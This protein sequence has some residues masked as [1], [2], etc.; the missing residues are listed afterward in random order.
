[1]DLERG[2][3]FLT[4]YMVRHFKRIVMQGMGLRD[5]RH[6]RNIY[7][8]HYTKVLYIGQTDDAALV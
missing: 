1:M 5:Y 3:F 2:T 4:D 6:L 7:F 8:A